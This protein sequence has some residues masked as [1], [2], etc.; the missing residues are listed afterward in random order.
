MLVQ[1]TKLCQGNYNVKKGFIYFHLNSKFSHSVPLISIIGHS[2]FRCLINSIILFK[3][4]ISKYL[5]LQAVNIVCFQQY[6]VKNWHKRGCHVKVFSSL[7]KMS[8]YHMLP[9][10]HF[11]INYVLQFFEYH[12][13]KLGGNLNYDLK[14]GQIIKGL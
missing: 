6:C 11:C 12:R 13:N 3:L 14:L 7:L 5:N 9:N 2:Q 8:P 10:G 4:Q 1:C